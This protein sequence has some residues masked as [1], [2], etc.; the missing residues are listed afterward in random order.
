MYRNFAQGAKYTTCVTHIHLLSKLLR[1]HE[2][3][4]EAEEVETE[5]KAVDPPGEAEEAEGEEA[6][7]RISHHGVHKVASP[8]TRVA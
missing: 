2:A 5:A 4:E 3:E 7:A 1:S 6:G 8:L